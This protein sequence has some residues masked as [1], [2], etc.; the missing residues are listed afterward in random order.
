MS[1]TRESESFSEK[2]VGERRLDLKSISDAGGFGS[3]GEEGDDLSTV[4]DRLR[5]EGGR[6]VLG[7]AV[8]SETERRVGGFD[9]GGRVGV[10]VV[11]D[12]F[13]S[14]RF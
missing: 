12:G 10:G 1:P 2:G 11:E 9:L 13:R 5:E 4:G 8:E 7:D 14:E 3:D 6:S